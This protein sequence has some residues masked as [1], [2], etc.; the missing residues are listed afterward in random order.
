MLQHG[1]PGPDGILGPDGLQDL[2]VTRQG[3]G[4]AAM[5]LEL[6]LSSLVKAVYDGVVE[7]QEDL[8]LR[9]LGQERMEG[10]VGLY[11]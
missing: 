8:V 5:D 9:G 11:P 4:C 10:G 6:T 2:T 1:L 7:P 3:T